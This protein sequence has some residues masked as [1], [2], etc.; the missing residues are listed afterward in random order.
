MVYPL[1]DTVKRN[2]GPG[3]VKSG[4]RESVLS[5]CYHAGL[6]R[7]LLKAAKKAPSKRLLRIIYT[8]SERKKLGPLSALPHCLWIASHS[9][10]FLI[11]LV[12]LSLK[13]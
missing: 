8:G 3:R 10:Y 1:Y 6:L 2:W 5:T 7:S 4:R 13:A 9:V 12:T 11:L